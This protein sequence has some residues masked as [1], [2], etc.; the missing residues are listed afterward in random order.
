MTVAVA[1]F[2]RARPPPLPS[3]PATPLAPAPPIA[4]LAISALLPS[5]TLP[6]LLK[7]PPP[8]PAPPATPMAWL[9]LIV[10][11]ATFSVPWLANAAAGD[12]GV[13]AD[14]AVGQRDSAGVAVAVVVHAAA[15]AVGRVAADGAVGQSAY[16][17]WP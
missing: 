11:E 9:L 16:C 4:V 14:R 5:A 10:L 7:M 15:A 13:A 3:P 8:M 17:A 12:G 1:L 6:P 2:S